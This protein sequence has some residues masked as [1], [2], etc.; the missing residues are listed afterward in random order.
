MTI[1]IALITTLLFG[2]LLT[3]TQPVFSQDDDDD[4]TTTSHKVEDIGGRLELLAGEEGAQLNTDINESTALIDA[5]AFVVNILL[6]LLGVFFFVYIFYAG[7][8]WFSAGG[9]EERVNKAK[10]LLRNNTIGIILVLSA[11]VIS[12]TVFAALRVAS[13]N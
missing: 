10:G 13:G 3:A 1:R 5:A 7:T 6:S 8:I 11:G 12:W 4:S 9:N 2:G